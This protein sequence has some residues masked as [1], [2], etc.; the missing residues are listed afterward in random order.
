MVASSPLAKLP[1]A[2]SSIHFVPRQVMLQ[3]NGAV[4]VKVDGK[5]SRKERKKRSS[6]TSQL[7][8]A[9]VGGMP[10]EGL[11]RDALLR[12]IAAFLDSNGFSKTLSVLLS[13]TQLEVIEI[14]LCKGR[15]NR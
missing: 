5:E 15:L 4:A 12:S 10:R 11:V 1:R 9:N 6:E 3:Q 2:P 7:D 13:E 14:P 8:E